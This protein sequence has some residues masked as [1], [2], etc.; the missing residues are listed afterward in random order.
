VVTVPFVYLIGRSEDAALSVN[1]MLLAILILVTY[2]IGCLAWSNKAGLLAAFL[3]AMYPP[4]IHLST[5]YR[6]HAAL[7]TSVAVSVW[8]LLLKTRFIKVAWL[9]GVS[10]GL[11][12]LIHPNFLNLMP[13]PAVIICLYMLLF[14]TSLTRPPRLLATPY[15]LL[16]K[17]CDP[18]VLSGLLPA[19]LIAA[20]LV[21]TWYLPRIQDILA[22]QQAITVYWS[23]QTYGFNGIPHSFW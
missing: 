9:F 23:D 1:I 22:L 4:I 5:I 2:G 8:L 17:L 12:M 11:G 7:P 10:M 13:I 3:V 14:Q 20:G 19:S 6:S 18:F 21:A 15:W 16:R